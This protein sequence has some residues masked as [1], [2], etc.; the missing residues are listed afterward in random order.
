MTAEFE[1]RAGAVRDAFVRAEI[2]VDAADVLAAEHHV[3]RDE[4]VIIGRRP[5]HGDMA[6]AQFRLRRA[7]PR[8]D[9]Q[10]RRMRGRRAV[11]R[12]FRLAARPAAECFLGQRV[13]R[14]VLAIANRHQ[15]RL[16]WK[17]RL[18]MK[19]SYVVHG[20]RRQRR[21]AAERRVAVGCVPIQQPREDALGDRARH[22]AQLN[23]AIQTLAAHAL[24][25]G[26][27]QRRPDDDVGEE[28]Q[29]TIGKPAERRDA[30]EHRV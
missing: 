20:D 10:P 12:P 2:Q 21:F 30:K 6:D 8:D 1:R 28:I 24:E 7:R 29:T 9:I 3:R 27:E 23:Q 26:V 25:V 13:N 4:R 17:Q 14:V 19:R 22:V 5:R 18:L 11:R 15:R 16:A